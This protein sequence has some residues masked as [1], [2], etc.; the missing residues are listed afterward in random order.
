MDKDLIFKAEH[1]LVDM[2]K[3]RQLTV[4]GYTIFPFLDTNAVDKLVGYYNS[5]QNEDPAHF[6]SSTHSPNKEFRK[7]TNEFIKAIISPLLDEYFKSYRL[8]GGAF[9]VKPANGKG[10]LPPHQDWNLVDETIARSYNI[11]IPLTDVNFEN[12]AVCVLPGSHRKMA[13]YRGP[14]IPSVFKN[15]E[16]LVWKN[17]QVLSMKAGE[18]LCYDHALLHASPVNTTAKIRLGIVCGIIAATSEMQL[19]FDGA[20]SVE[21]YKIDECFFMEEDPTKGPEGLVSIKKLLKQKPLDAEE[22]SKKYLNTNK[23][24]FWLKRLF[25]SIREY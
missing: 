14:G 16:P 5:F 24:T 9:V 25:S 4:D 21:A 12:G 19:Y 11:W 1:I 7:K 18:A 17:L 2:E 13:T 23:K 10:L 3:D 8:L 6:Y 20:D 22:F 15:I